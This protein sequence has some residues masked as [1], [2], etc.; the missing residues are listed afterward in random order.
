M[1]S[2]LTYCMWWLGSN[3]HFCAFLSELCFMLRKYLR[4]AKQ[5]VLWI[6]LPCEKAASSVHA[7]Y[8]N[9]YHGCFAKIPN[10]NLLNWLAC[11]SG[12][13]MPPVHRL[14][15]IS[16]HWEG[17]LWVL[18]CFLQALRDVHMIH[19]EP[20]TTIGDISIYLPHSQSCFKHSGPFIPPSIKWSLLSI[21]KTHK[22]RK[23]SGKKTNS[24]VSSPTFHWFINKFTRAV[25][26][27]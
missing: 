9:S 2:H 8:W 13:S 12:N 3:P 19:V 25:P 18:W 10:Q 6:L 22:F 27:L 7:A 11:D 26:K 16:D 17:S 20:C 1:K 15:H 21:Y 23:S 24:V 4:K 5:E 14:R